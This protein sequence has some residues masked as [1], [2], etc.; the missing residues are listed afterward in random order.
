MWFP[1]CSPLS[2]L[3][4]KRANKLRLNNQIS[5]N[6]IC[7]FVIF[8][9]MSKWRF[10]SHYRVSELQTSHYCGYL[11]VALHLVLRY[12]M[13]YY[14]NKLINKTQREMKNSTFTVGYPNKMML[15]TFQRYNLIIVFLSFLKPDRIT[16]K[17][18]PSW[19]AFF[20][21]WRLKYNNVIFFF[22]YDTK[23]LYDIT[24]S[25]PIKSNIITDCQSSI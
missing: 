9:L 12:V 22:S 1:G 16:K 10:N 19:I 8:R 25:H 4:S 7:G 5:V 24:D 20:I 14:A 17:N 21:Q 6:R 18:P 23:R 13:L 15:K 11:A 2:C 3:I